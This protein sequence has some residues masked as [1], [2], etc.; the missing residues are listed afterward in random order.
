VDLRD[1]K[2][3]VQGLHRSAIEPHEQDRHPRDIDILIDTVRDILQGELVDESDYSTRRIKDLIESRNTLLNRIGLFGMRKSSAISANKKLRTIVEKEWVFD[4]P[5][6]HEVFL[7]MKDAYMGADEEA[8]KELVKC[9]DE[10]EDPDSEEGLVVRSKFTRLKYLEES[11]EADE[12]LTAKLEQ[13]KDAHP[14]WTL[15]EHP[16]LLGYVSEPRWVGSNPRKEADE[17]L[18]MEPSEVVTWLAESEGDEEGFDRREGDIRQVEA[19][20][21]KAPSWGVKLLTDLFESEGAYEGLWIRAILGLTDGQLKE[22]DWERLLSLLVRHKDKI[23][24]YRNIANLLTKGMRAKSIPTSSISA[25]NEVIRTLWHDCKEP[26]WENVE[27]WHRRAINTPHGR[28]AEYWVQELSICFNRGEEELEGMPFVSD[29]LEEIAGLLQQGD[30]RSKLAVAGITPFSDFLLNVDRAWTEYTIVPQLKFDNSPEAAKAAWSG[31]NYVQQLSP[32]FEEAFRSSYMSL[33]GNLDKGPVEFNRGLVRHVAIFAFYTA[34]DPASNWLHPFLQE[35]SPELRLSLIKELGGIFDDLDLDAQEYA[36]NE[37]LKE[38]VRDYCRGMPVKPTPQE[39]GAMVSWVKDSE[40]LLE[41]FLE[42]DPL[43]N[44]T[45]DFGEVHLGLIQRSELVEE[46]PEE[47]AQYVQQL[48]Y[49]LPEQDDSYCP[50]ICYEM[51]QLI[52]KGVD[53]E[54]MRD[55]ADR[56]RELG[57]SGTERLFEKLSETSV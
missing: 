46:K 39:R 42:L 9:I 34:D 33:F 36:W 38:F 48:V 56:V 12:L 17:I 24:H 35:A 3:V 31:M 11:G 47:V 20:V 14:D 45:L 37:W 5:R 19:A 7:L 15:G 25:A 26:G 54:K 18:K 4:V 28:I 6:K 23:S 51:E 29:I 8:R 32:E 22:D 50:R 40:L 30:V 49:S 53:G 1:N 21:S 41:E 27:E 10:Y 44:E 13:I 52:D 57:C 43:W 16:D 55:A 2:G